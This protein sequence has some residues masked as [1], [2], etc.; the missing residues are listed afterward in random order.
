MIVLLNEWVE[1]VIDINCVDFFHVMFY[2]DLW[3]KFNF[4][5]CI[6]V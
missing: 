4:F 1:V 5:I 3:F 6:Y 2:A